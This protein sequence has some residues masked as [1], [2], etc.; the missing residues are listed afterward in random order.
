MSGSSL[1]NLSFNIKLDGNFLTKKPVHSDYLDDVDKPSYT[2]YIWSTT[3]SAKST[4]TLCSSAPSLQTE[5]NLHAHAHTRTRVM[6][7]NP[8]K[9][10]QAY[11]T[12]T[13]THPHI[14]QAPYFVPLVQFP[15]GFYENTTANVGQM[16]IH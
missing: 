16:R 5:M 1:F 2:K 13:H 10:A 11:R 4:L 12:H 3:T 15:Q 7:T 8:H 9:H 6:H 14:H